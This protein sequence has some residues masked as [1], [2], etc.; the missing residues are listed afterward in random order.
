MGGGGSEDNVGLTLSGPHSYFDSLHGGNGNQTRTDSWVVSIF[1][2]KFQAGG[3]YSGG[4]YKKRREPAKYY[5]LFQEPVGRHI[6]PLGSGSYPA[7]GSSSAE[8]I[9]V[10]EKDR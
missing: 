1:L 7:T 9:T 2:A 10:S 4:V 3:A 6:Q 8:K 5:Q